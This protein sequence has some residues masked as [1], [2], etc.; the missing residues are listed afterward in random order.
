MNVFQLIYL[1]SKYKDNIL[2]NMSCSQKCH[3]HKYVMSQKFVM[4]RHVS[5]K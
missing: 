5:L 3:V 1:I 4:F 2:R